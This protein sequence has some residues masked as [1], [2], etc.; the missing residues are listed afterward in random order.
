ML[1]LIQL[2]IVCATPLTA[3]YMITRTITKIALAKFNLQLETDTYYLAHK[4]L[5]KEKEEQ[6]LK[7][8][9]QVP[10]KDSIVGRYFPGK[11]HKC[12]NFCD[13]PQHDHD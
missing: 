11:S 7:L 6:E 5:C 3:L 1:E 10:E 12:S 8:L 9:L 2:F 13:P 4:R